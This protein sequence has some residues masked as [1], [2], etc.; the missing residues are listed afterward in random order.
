M[1][2]NIFSIVLFS[3][4]GVILFLYIRPAYDSLQAKQAKI[5]EYDAAL[6]K[7]NELQQI[8]QD[9]TTKFNS[10]TSEEQT[11]LDKLLPDHVDNVA[12]I[13]DMDHLAG[14]HSMG[15]ENVDVNTMSGSKNTP[16]QTAVGIVA[17]DS[18]QK[19]DSLT[20]TFNTRGTY[21]NFIAFMRDLQNSLRIVDL[22][23]LSL[24]PETSTGGELTYIYKVALQTYWLK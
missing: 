17:A 14:Q 12:L 20:I 15:L 6:S 13:L 16:G 3:L 5:A 19:Y 21:S 18:G 10:F 7:A 11:R 9:L 1:I 2:R 24:T 4:A 22:S 8:K 23:S